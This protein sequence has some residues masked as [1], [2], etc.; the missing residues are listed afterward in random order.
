[1]L[2][3][4]S[5]DDRRFQDLVDDAKRLVQRRC[6]EWTDHN[7]SDPGVTLIE[8]VALMVD[9]LI[10]RLNRT[11]DRAYVHFL[12]LV[13]IHLHPP[14]AAR[15]PVTL[16][17]SAPRE[18]TL[19]VPPGTEVSTV[20]TEVEDPV[21]FRTL[22]QLDIVSCSRTHVATADG[23]ATTDRT[24]AILTGGFACFSA[25]PAVGDAML[26]GLS[27]AV[28]SCAVRL[29][30]QCRV[31]GVGVNPRYPPLVWEA[32]V[33]D[34]AWAECEVDVDETGGLNRPGDVLLHVP[35]DHVEWAIAGNRAG[36]I[37]CRVV[38]PL[39]GQPSYRSSPQ[40][41]DVVGDTVGG[42][43]EAMH[44]H[45]ITDELLGTSNGLPGQ[46][47]PLA[48]RPVVPDVLDEVLEVS[49][50]DGWQPWRL[51]P[52]P[53][54]AGPDDPV[55]MLE[56]NDGE[57]V[58]GPSV[59]ELDG[60]LRRHGA[61]PP[62]G[63]V[64]RMSRYAAGGGAAGNV[65]AHALQQLRTS[66]PYVARVD[67]RTAAVG[68]VDGETLDEARDRAPL[69]LRTRFRAVTAEDFELLAKEVAAELPRIHCVST[70]EP[71]GGRAIR[72]L[73]VPAA[74]RAADGSLAFVD[75][76]PPDEVVHRIAAYL[77]ERRLVGTRLVVEPPYYQGVTVVARLRAHPGE[78]GRLLKL[79]AIEALNRHLDPL[80]GGPN[81]MGWPLGR[82]VQT[83]EV[84]SLLQR[85]P[86]VD[87][88]EDVRLFAADTMTGARADAPAQRIDLTPTQLVFSYE[89]QVVV[90]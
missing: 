24:D 34:D 58:L 60:S 25:R 70:V 29:R 26:V 38:E 37:R 77:D 89:H 48:F 23:Q 9:Q 11:P 73:V 78:T 44:A 85:L 40:V 10:Y 68:G 18:D 31:E 88:V 43:T 87:L 22:Q 66:I 69:V 1:V 14:T 90:S 45:V 57:V 2:I 82:P 5:L 36:W 4:P 8:T 84:S 35:A 64:L 19:S 13:G 28:P 55:F 80:V 47:F 86:G 27:H 49:A 51:V 67:N 72:L 42:T 75:L 79:A 16:W 15:V 39:P 21:V 53:S 41:S 7:V 56:R 12:D 65:A 20:R 32:C 50:D 33:G 59:R 81:G 63:S 83:G 61:A 46:R 3:A 74:S 52:D 62:A 30:F 76:K 17:L 6:P 54:S 71:D